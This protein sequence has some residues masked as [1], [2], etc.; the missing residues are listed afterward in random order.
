MIA[1]ILNR[2]AL[3]ILAC[4]FLSGCGLFTDSDQIS[5]CRAVI[6]ILHPDG[7]RIDMSA[8]TVEPG[9]VSLRYTTGEIGKLTPHLLVC[10]FGSFDEGRGRLLDS[11]E[12]ERRTFGPAQIQFLN[13]FAF[14]D[15]AFFE[16]APKLTPSEVE[17]LPRL[18]PGMGE[19]LQQLVAQAPVPVIYGLL[20][21]AYA[22][23][24]GLIGR[25]NLAFGPFVSLGGIA[26]GI[27]FLMIIVTESGATLAAVAAACVVAICVGA[28][29]GEFVSSV[30]FR[31][32]LKRPGQQ[33]LVASAGLFIALQEFLRLMQG[34]RAVWLPSMTGGAVPIAVTEHFV[35]TVTPS[36]MLVTVAGLVPC[37]AL[38]LVLKYSG[39]GRRWRAVADDAFAAELFGVSPSHILG[40]SFAIAGAMTGFCG[41]LI[42]V[43][44]GGIGFAD[45]SPFALKALAGAVIGGIGSV[46]G[47]MTGGILIGV[48]EGLWSSTLSIADREIAIF[49]LLVLFLT[50]RPGGLF[51]FSDQ[52]PRSV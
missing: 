15:P 21:A 40:I 4:A 18:S 33:V 44:Y 34:E 43:H 32:M 51:G 48:M 46:G 2:L 52:K 16:L 3:L 17:G 45:G 30:I 41:F 42:S 49:A 50:L 26:A 47:A 20:G 31:P 28:V 9:V 35:V 29:W 24:Y 13:N 10:R 12:T 38:L 36:A 19:A 6:G 27:G 11:V 8:R 7:T 23:I 37:L 39:F 1:P 22:L 5:R 14:G 25:I